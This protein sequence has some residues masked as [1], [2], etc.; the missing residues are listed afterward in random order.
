MWCSLERFVFLEF[1]NKPLDSGYKI[2]NIGTN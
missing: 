1:I 2:V